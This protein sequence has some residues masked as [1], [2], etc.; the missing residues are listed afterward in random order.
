MPTPL[1]LNSQF[2][3]VGDTPSRNGQLPACWHGMNGVLN[4]IQ[5][6][7]AEI[8]FIG[9]CAQLLRHILPEL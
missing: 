5:D 8:T 1:S 9:K 2:D 7:N 4:Q 6:D 3:T